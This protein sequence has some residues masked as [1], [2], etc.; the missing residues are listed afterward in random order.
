MLDTIK[1]ICTTCSDGLTCVRRKSH[2]QP[3]WYCEEF[4]D[5]VPPSI[6]TFRGNSVLMPGNHLFKD[7]KAEQDMDKRSGV[8]INCRTR[9]ECSFFELGS[10]IWQCNEYS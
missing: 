4:D 1:D 7:R 9:N 2:G 10:D 8:C 5:Y 6:K 3:V